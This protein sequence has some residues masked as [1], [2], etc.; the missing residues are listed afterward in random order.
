MNFV[1]EAEQEDDRRWLAGVLE[2]PGVLALRSD[3]GAG[4]CNSEDPDPGVVAER[5]EQR[6]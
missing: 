3:T 2:L 6:E 1:V 4:Q 5:L